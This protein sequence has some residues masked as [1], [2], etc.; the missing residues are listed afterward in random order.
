VCEL[1][2]NGI[3]SRYEVNVG[4]WVPEVTDDDKNL[5]HAT[6]FRAKDGH[7]ASYLASNPTRLVKD[8]AILATNIG[9]ALSL[10]GSTLVHACDNSDNPNICVRNGAT[11]SKTI[12]PKSQVTETATNSGYILYSGAS[13]VRGVDP[14]YN[15]TDKKI[16]TFSFEG[17]PVLFFVKGIV[18]IAT[19]VESSA[20][21]KSYVILRPWNSKSAVVVDTGTP[22]TGSASIDAVF[23]GTNFVV[24]HHTNK[25]I[26]KVVKIPENATRS[27]F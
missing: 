5:V 9:G 13:K 4:E 24:A 6:I 21:N 7:W 14:V 8:N 17:K 15:D 10:S 16:G 1:V 12:I 27:Q 20:T 2:D 18:W 19:S 26:L 11:L 22:D 3:M 25:G 23:D